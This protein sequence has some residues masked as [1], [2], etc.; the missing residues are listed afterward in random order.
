MS[1]HPLIVHPGMLEV[2]PYRVLLTSHGT[3]AAA[4]GLPV[5]KNYKFGGDCVTK[6]SNAAVA[7]NVLVNGLQSSGV[8]I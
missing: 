7:P 3:H 4:S 2:D 5:F 1:V 8:D 6:I